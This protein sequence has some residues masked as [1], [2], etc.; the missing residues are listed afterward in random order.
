MLW[1]LRCAKRICSAKVERVVVNA[2]ANQCGFAAKFPGLP[3]ACAYQFGLWRILAI[4]FGEADPP[5][6]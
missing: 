4:V 2:L 1:L 3:R 6:R 5:L